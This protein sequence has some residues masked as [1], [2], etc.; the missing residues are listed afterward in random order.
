M[1][2]NIFFLL[3]LKNH[4]WLFFIVLVWIESPP[5]S[6][7]FIL[8]PRV[9]FNANRSNHRGFF[10]SFWLF[11]KLSLQKG[12]YDIIKSPLKSRFVWHLLAIYLRGRDRTENG[13]TKN[14]FG[15]VFFSQPVLSCNTISTAVVIITTYYIT[16]IN[17][18][19]PWLNFLWDIRIIMSINHHGAWLFCVNL[20]IRCLCGTQ[21]RPEKHASTIPAPPSLC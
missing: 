13:E 15:W 16:C 21:P 6:I 14:L 3:I 18:R 19:T 20:W 17:C 4:Y 7:W 2:N 12:N 11:G 5:P 8:A 1:H 9:E 10:K